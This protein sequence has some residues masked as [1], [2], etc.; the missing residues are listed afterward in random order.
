MRSLSIVLLLLLQSLAFCQ[1]K[2]SQ[3]KENQQETNVYIP[4]I[5]NAGEKH[6]YRV[7]ETKYK[8]GKVKSVKTQIL[9]LKILSVED[10]EIEATMKIVPQVDQATLR[11]IESDPVSKAFK[12]L[13]GSLVFE[14]VI[15][16]DGVF[17]EFKNI[18][19]IEAAVAKTR[20][21][22]VGILEEMKPALMAR[23]A[24]KMG[25]DPS[26]IDPAEIDRVFAVLLKHQGSTETAIEK[27]LTPLN[28]ILQ[29][30]N[31]EHEVGKPKVDQTELDM[32]IVSA[33][34]AT[35]TYRVMEVDR[36]S[37]LAVIQFQQQVKGQ[38]AA[39]KYQ[40]ALDE[41]VQEMDPKHKPRTDLPKV[42]VLF[43][44][45]TEGRMDLNSGWPQTVSW[46]SKLNNLKDDQLAVQ[47]KVEVQRVEPEK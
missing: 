37:N 26:E 39:T 30:V 28:L 45:S 47:R 25:K 17:S 24:E 38:E 5:C 2:E 44:S 19:E 33:L 21:M 11:K 34:P 9:K 18:K 15:T 7:T 32:G 12:E 4:F 16:P 6:T 13:W 42:T 20:E 36:Q 35:E 27:M 31:T 14:V 8:N 3:E 22:V 46:S 40:K 23:R 43:D 29:F 1:E 41:L 10:K